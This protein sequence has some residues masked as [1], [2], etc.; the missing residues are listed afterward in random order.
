MKGT[1]GRV[2]RVLVGPISGGIYPIIRGG[3]DE[4]IKF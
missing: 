3:G 1:R 2:V 4:V